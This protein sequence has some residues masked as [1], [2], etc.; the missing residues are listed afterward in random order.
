MSSLRFWVSNV[1]HVL[2]LFGS[3][4][5]YVNM[6][7]MPLYRHGR[8]GQLLDPQ[9]RVIV[10]HALPNTSWVFVAGDRFPRAVRHCKLAYQTLYPSLQWT[11]SSSARHHGMRHVRGKVVGMRSA[12]CQPKDLRIGGTVTT[13]IGPERS[14]SSASA[15]ASSY[16]GH[17]VGLPIV[18]QD[19]PAQYHG[20][21]TATQDNATYRQIRGPMSRR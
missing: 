4:A 11:S 21:R 1:V 2:E 16:C 12:G 3:R 9:Y 5:I 17:D 14:A 13:M 10:I 8:M 7:V 18:P 20:I 19:T 15:R 6:Q